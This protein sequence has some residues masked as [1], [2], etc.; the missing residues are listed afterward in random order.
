MHKELSAIWAINPNLLQCMQSHIAMEQN[1]VELEVRKLMVCFSCNS[2]FYPSSCSC[3]VCYRL[4]SKSDA[5]RQQNLTTYI[6]QPNLDFLITCDYQIDLRQEKH[7]DLINLA[8]SQFPTFTVVINSE[9]VVQKEKWSILQYCEQFSE[10][11]E[12]LTVRNT[13]KTI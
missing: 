10:H 1:I 13:F 7:N 4:R 5:T 12:Y 11:I 3:F 6:W 8:K 2:I 9:S